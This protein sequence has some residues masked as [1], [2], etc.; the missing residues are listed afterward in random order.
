MNL[1]ESKVA[2]ITG[3][4]SGIGEKTAEIFAEQGAKVVIAARR[5]EKLQKL[6]EKIE[7]A[8][9]EAFPVKADVSSKADCDNLVAATI[10][11]YGRIDVLVNNAGIADKHRSILTCDEDW[12]KSIVAVN[13]DSVYY[14]TKAVVTHMM[15]QGTGSIINVSSIGG[16]F[17][18]AGIAYSS[19]KAAVNGMTKNLAIQ[20]AGTGIR[21][22]AVCPGPTE[23][24]LF[25]E[26][27]FEGMDKEFSKICAG[28]CCYDVPKAKAV[29]QA[30]AILFFGSDL[31]SAVTG[32]IVV[33]DKGFT[34]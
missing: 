7:S 2:I 6:K 5:I 17:G 31:S 1:L 27:N 28:H 29:E 11:K 33:V 22:N 24:P 19:A 3:A 34:L 8:G 10:E 23:T 15:K 26:V 16:V 13:Q 32:Q 21:C 20:F 9:G 14:M 12:Y 4:S 25:D 30:N 18:N